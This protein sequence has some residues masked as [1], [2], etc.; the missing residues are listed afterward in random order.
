MKNIGIY[1]SIG[2]SI[3]IFL[4]FNYYLDYQNNNTHEKERNKSAELFVDTCEEWGLDKKEL[5]F[6][7]KTNSIT[8]YC[9]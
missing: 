6:E 1:I 7:T 4:F 9:K 8:F 3:I 5:S 2:I